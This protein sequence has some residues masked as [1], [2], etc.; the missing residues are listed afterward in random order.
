ME[1][2]KERPAFKVDGFVALV[3]LGAIAILAIWWLWTTIHGW[4]AILG[5]TLKITDF[6]GEDTAAE[7][8][9]WLGATLIAVVIPTFSGFFTVEPNQA[10]VVTFLGRYAGSVRGCLKSFE[11]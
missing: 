6:L 11:G 9:A 2:L 10:V 5:R 1:R 3:V 4:E 7:I 8:S